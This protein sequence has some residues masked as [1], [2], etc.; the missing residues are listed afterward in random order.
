MSA[1]GLHRVLEPAGVLPQ[2][3][4]R[5]DAGPGL[6]ADDEVRIR[7]RRLNLDAASYRQLVSEHGVD[8]VRDAV[9]AIVTERGKMQNPV[10]GSG[11]ML[12]G[13]VEEVGPASPLGL[14]AGDRV[15]TLVSLTL[16]PLALT[17]GLA[18]WDGRSEQVPCD[19]HA[20]LFGRSIAA[21]LPSDLTP[22]LALAVLDVCGAPA[23]TTRV[24]TQALTTAGRAG[25]QVHPVGDHGA[26]EGR[27]GGGRPV[28]EG[29][30][31]SVAVLGG[32]GKSGSLS[33]AAARRAG[34]T[35][36]VG[37][38]PT[39]TEAAA[40]TAAGLATEVVVADARDP[41][42]LAAAI[43]EPVDVTV[44]CVDVPGCE[45]GA[46][47]ATRAGGTV[48]FFSMAT[49]FPAAALGAEG[50]AAD[51]TML[52]GNGYAPGHAELALDLVRT[53]PGVRALFDAR[54]TPEA[55]GQAPGDRTGDGSSRGGD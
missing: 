12:V 41:V 38:V 25:D 46:I 37:V 7:V 19:G 22:E 6:A 14:A 55:P 24:V 34:A 31:V 21:V 17:D 45:H 3:A 26:Q 50:L 43:G 15:A 23:L 8:G 47:L 28:G 16:T 20:I 10:T 36:L 32:G 1:I 9:V 4:R 11:G 49:S 27:P 39:E 29:D 52:I 51:V 5:L 30:P 35:R 42:G 13:V 40:L 44:V 54:L 2:A 33:L 48:V 53:D 18:R